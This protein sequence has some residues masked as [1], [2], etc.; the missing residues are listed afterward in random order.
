M[1]ERTFTVTARALERAIRLLPQ[2][3]VTPT[4]SDKDRQHYE[5]ALKLAEELMQPPRPVPQR[6]TQ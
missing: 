4:G 6:T 5:H 1:S 3:L 2:N